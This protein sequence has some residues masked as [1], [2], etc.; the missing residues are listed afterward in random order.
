MNDITVAVVMDA[1][2]IN[3]YVY[4]MKCAVNKVSNLEYYLILFFLFVPF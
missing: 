4:E 3:I 2:S 1:N